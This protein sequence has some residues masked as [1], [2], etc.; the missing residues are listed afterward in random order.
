MPNTKTTDM[1]A[2]LEARALLEKIGRQDR[3]AFQHFY[4]SYS[5]R[6]ARYASTIL[7]REDWIDELVNDVMMVVWQNAAKF[8]PTSRV[9]SW[10]FGIA[11]NKALKILEKHYR[12]RED[13]LEISDGDED[14]ETF[15]I[16]DETTPENILSSEHDTRTVKWALD[17]LSLEH[18]TVM[19]LAF[20]EEYSYP[21]IAEIVGCP[22]NTVKTR[23]FHARKRLQT[24][25]AQYADKGNTY[26]QS[27]SVN[28]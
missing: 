24:L 17:Q 22:A 18:R 6:I 9:T 12:R 5:P 19:E 2:E 7:K 10:L 13:S 11:H 26:D 15:D 25:L 14:S 28:A 1:N 8:Q 21:E 20:Y 4:F 23:M 27:A 16:P 3:A